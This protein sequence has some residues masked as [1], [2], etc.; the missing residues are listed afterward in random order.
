MQENAAISV[1]A[2]RRRNAPAR[3]SVDRRASDI[4]G[5]RSEPKQDK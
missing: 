3:R 4:L 2:V 5:E 1:D